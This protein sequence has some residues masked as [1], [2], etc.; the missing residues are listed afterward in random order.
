MKE[1]LEQPRS[2]RGTMQSCH[3]TGTTHWPA[4]MGL[5]LTVGGNAGSVRN[6]YLP[7][8]QQKWRAS[9]TVFRDT[10]LLTG[11]FTR[12]PLRLINNKEG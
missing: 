1:L 12:G 6:S 9:S 4:V 7:L 8:F 5:L 2:Q 10:V 3:G 11:I